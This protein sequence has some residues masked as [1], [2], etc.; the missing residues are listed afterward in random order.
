MWG[1]GGDVSNGIAYC[2]FFYL[3]S[4]FLEHLYEEANARKGKIC[5]EFDKFSRD[6]CEDYVASIEFL[7]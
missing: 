6:G 7:H 5:N 4:D 2:S 1:E 3:F